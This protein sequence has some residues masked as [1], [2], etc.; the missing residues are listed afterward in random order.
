MIIGVIIGAL[1]GT[2]AGYSI[3]LILELSI[4]LAAVMFLLPKC[5]ELIGQGIGPVSQ[6]LK[7]WIQH[8]F[9]KKHEL[10]VAV[11]PEVLMSNKSVMITGLILMPIALIIALVLPGNKVLPL[12]DL[13]NLISIMAVTVLVSRGNVIRSIV[14]GIPIVATFLLISTHVAGLITEL[15]V[16]TGITFG[17][18]QKITAFTDGG[19]HIRFFLLYLFQGNWIAIAIIP[20]FLCMMFLSYR[21]AE[22]LKGHKQ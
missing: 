22:V 11:N 16:K 8:R 5:G 7:V 18:G 15:S 17:A 13:P 1:L 9:P 21:R 3:K 19:N 12:G 2:T 4:H 10:Y 6:A 20:V 14:T